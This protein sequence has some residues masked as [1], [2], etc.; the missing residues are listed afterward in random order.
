MSDALSLL[1]V[2]RDGVAARDEQHRA[3]KEG[4]SGPPNW[5]IPPAV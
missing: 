3:L 4:R 1:Y 5:G 2:L